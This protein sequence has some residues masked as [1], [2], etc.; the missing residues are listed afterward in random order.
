MPQY[1]FRAWKAIEDT[2]IHDAQ[3]MRRGLRGKTPVRAGELRVVVVHGCLVRRARM[4]V[5]R[6]IK[7]RQRFPQR[8]HPRIVKI[9]QIV[10]ALDLGIPVYH[11]PL[12]A[13]LSNAALKF[14]HGLFGVLEREGGHTDVTV[15]MRAHLFGE[16]VVH[17]AGSL[18]RFGP[19]E[20]SL[21]AEGAKPGT[22]RQ[23]NFVNPYLVH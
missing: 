19:V 7:C 6:Y 13:E 3:R 1:D 23:Q 17:Y 12:E 22:E 2:A 15:R 5:E 18:L 14:A 11:D 9:D 8:R 10:W 4:K 20:Y 16:K 21:H